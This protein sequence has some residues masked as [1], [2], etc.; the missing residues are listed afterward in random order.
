[1]RQEG[2]AASLKTAESLLTLW[3]EIDRLKVADLD[4]WGWR[5]Y[6]LGGLFLVLGTALLGA[7]LSIG[8]VPTWLAVL[9]LTVGILLGAATLVAGL[10]LFVVWSLLPKKI[11]DHVWQGRWGEQT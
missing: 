6:A 2:P 3:Q 1:G 9:E 8:R 4:R 5:V 7:V 11:R 10:A